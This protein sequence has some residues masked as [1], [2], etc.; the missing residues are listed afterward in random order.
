MNGVYRSSAK[1]MG[2]MPKRG[3]MKKAVISADVIEHN[4]TWFWLSC[5][6][7]RGA[8]LTF[9]PHQQPPSRGPSPTTQLPGSVAAPAVAAAAAPPFQ[10]L[11]RSTTPSDEDASVAGA[12]A[13][14]VFGGRPAQYDAHGGGRPETGLAGSVAVGDENVR[15]GSR[16]VVRFL[17]DRCVNRFNAAPSEMIDVYNVTDPAV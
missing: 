7:S 3:S 5:A 11:V 17:A 16:A 14:H 6:G 13:G 1:P 2:R 8:S 9:H 10:R 4:L 12:V 15:P